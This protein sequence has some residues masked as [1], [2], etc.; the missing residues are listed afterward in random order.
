MMKRKMTKDQWLEF[1][2]WFY[3]EREIVKYWHVQLNI[4]LYYNRALF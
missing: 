1:V 3:A 2:I 4:P